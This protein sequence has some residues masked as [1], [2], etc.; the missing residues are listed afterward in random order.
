VL[1]RD[2]AGVADWSLDAIAMHEC[3]PARQP[4]ICGQSLLLKGPYWLEICTA[5]RAHWSKPLLSGRK[6]LIDIHF[7]RK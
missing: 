7:G 3:R 1:V 5:C 2:N 4:R 6:T